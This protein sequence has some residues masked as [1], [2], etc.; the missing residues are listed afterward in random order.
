MTEHDDADAEQLTSKRFDVELFIVHPTVDPAEISVALGLDAKFAHRVGDQRKTPA[1][2]LLSG[3]HRDTRWRHSRRYETGDQWFADKVVDLIDR[4]EPHKEFLKK[5][6]I[7]GGKACVIVQF[8]GDGYFG[9]EVPKD[10]LSRLA[11]MELDL[12]IECFTRS[13][14]CRRNRETFRSSTALTN[15]TFSIFQATCERIR[16]SISR[17]SAGH[18]VR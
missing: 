1:G 18:P 2:T 10:V 7:T 12:G 15:S 16:P 13:S 4:L 14:R 8:L 3:V 11:D 5:L 6:T 17:A 9:D